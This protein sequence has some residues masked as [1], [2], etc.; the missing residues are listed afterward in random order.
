[1]WT[2][3]LGIGWSFTSAQDIVDLDKLRMDTAG[4]TGAE[5][6]AS[7]KAD[8]RVIRDPADNSI[9]QVKSSV[10][11]ATE[12]SFRALDMSLVYLFALDAIGDFT[13]RLNASYIEDYT[14]QLLPI[15]ARTQGAGKQNDSTG[16]VPPL[17]RLKGHAALI[18]LSGDQSA[19][20]SVLYT[21]EVTY[22]SALAGLARFYGKS[23]FVPEDLEAWVQVN[24]QYQVALDSLITGG[25]TTTLTFGVQNLFDEMAQP[26]LLWEDMKDSCTAHSVDAS[27]FDSHISSD[28]AS[29]ARGRRPEWLAWLNPKSMRLQIRWP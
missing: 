8:A 14:Y 11:N 5:W 27:I 28:K 15:S 9:T 19:N 25:S 2:S 26:I 1:M 24:A 6:I 7:G 13:F 23:A 29:E 10:S 3:T 17:P 16:A 20:L 22:D 12:M 18:W 21:D 4:L